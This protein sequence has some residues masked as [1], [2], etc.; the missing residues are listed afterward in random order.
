[1]PPDVW[2]ASSSAHFDVS[3]TAAAWPFGTHPSWPA[4]NSFYD[5]TPD[6][7]RPGVYFIRE[8]W[9]EHFDGHDIVLVGEHGQPIAFG[10]EGVKAAYPGYQTM[11]DWKGHWDST[12]P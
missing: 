12:H 8:E 7:F 11:S 1:M 2:T 9:R 10:N 4:R 6:G 5:G 3:S